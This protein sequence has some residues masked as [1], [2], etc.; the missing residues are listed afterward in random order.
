MSGTASPAPETRFRPMARGLRP[1]LWW[2]V[3]VLVLFAWR[4]HE[5]LS[6][7]THLAF[8]VWLQNRSVSY[9]AATQLDGKP[10]SSG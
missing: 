6:E 10:I 4:T 8:G 3:L 9:E 5:R 1:L 7:Q 2:L